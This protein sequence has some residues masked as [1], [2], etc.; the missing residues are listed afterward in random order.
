MT[1]SEIP[2]PQGVPW[3][4]TTRK[5]RPAP[6]FAKSLHPGAAELVSSTLSD[7]SYRK[8]LEELRRKLNR[9]RRTVAAKLETLEIHPWL[10]PRGG[11]YLWCRLPGGRDA[12]SVAHAALRDGVILA[13]G[14]V[15]SASQTASEFMRF[16]VAQMNSA[17]IFSVLERTLS[18]ET[19]AYSR[20]EQIPGAHVKRGVHLRVA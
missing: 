4:L 6:T 11:F 8:H 15:F 10:M 18:L 19:N 2:L 3:R 17:Q 20:S 16:N 9:V 7:G 12:A 1:F 14:N 13:P 5:I